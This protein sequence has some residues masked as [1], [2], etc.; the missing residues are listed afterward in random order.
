MS[1]WVQI[2]GS[3]GQRLAIRLIQHGHVLEQKVVTTH[4]HAW[5]LKLTATHLQ[6]GRASI[7]VR[8]PATGALVLPDTVLG[9]PR[10]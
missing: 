2:S 6:A 10:R 5:N 8:S 3:P 7:V 1:V 9:A 4:T